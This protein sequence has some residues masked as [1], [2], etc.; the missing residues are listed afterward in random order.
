MPEQDYVLVDAYKGDGSIVPLMLETAKQNARFGKPSFTAEF[1]GNWNG[2][3]HPRLRADIRSGIWSNAMTNIAG[4]P[5]T[6]WYDFIDRF[7]LHA[8]FAALAKFMEGEDYRCFAGTTR[9]LNA[10]PS[11]VAVGFTDNQ[12]GYFWAIDRP[13]SETW[14]EER[15]MPTHEGVT[16]AVPG[17]LP[18]HYHVE[19][20]DPTTGD[21]LS[22]AAATLDGA[23][24]SPPGTGTLRIAL[25]RFR[26]DIA[27]KIRPA[28]E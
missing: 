28:D 20:W 23:D 5:F 6:W 4:A 18:G 22:T 21:I 24:T 11:L 15:R 10:A 1:G 17:M 3:T 8:D 12:R 25:P 16:L 9:I 19:F 26:I 2:T 27:G 13:A 14:P 7:G